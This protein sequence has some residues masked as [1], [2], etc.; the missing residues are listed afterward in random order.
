MSGHLRIYAELQSHGARGP[1]YQVRMNRA[2]GMVIVNATTEP[3]FAAARVLLSKGVTGRL[4]LWDSARPFCRL[5]GDIE[6]MAAFTVSEGQDGIAL[7]KYTDRTADGDFDPE[8][9]DDPEI[10]N[11]RPA[12]AVQASSSIREA[13]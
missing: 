8:A 3:L 13:A 6:R 9:S 10:E 11:G 2:D 4:Q 12:R 5:Q 7:R 1:R